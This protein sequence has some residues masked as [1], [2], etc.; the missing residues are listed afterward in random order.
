MSVHSGTMLQYCIHS[1]IVCFPLLLMFT[2]VL[3]IKLQLRDH[4]T[5]KIL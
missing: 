5:K 1:S 4:V 3:I 2:D